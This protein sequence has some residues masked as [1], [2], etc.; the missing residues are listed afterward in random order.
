MTIGEKIQ[1]LRKTNNLSRAVG[2]ELAVSRQ[3]IS[4]WELGESI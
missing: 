1:Q 4:K 3:A 2:G